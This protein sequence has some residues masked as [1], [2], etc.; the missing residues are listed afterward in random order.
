M[1]LKQAV[2]GMPAATTGVTEIRTGHIIANIIVRYAISNARGYPSQNRPS[3]HPRLQGSP[4]RGRMSALASRPSLPVCLDNAPQAH[5]VRQPILVVR[6]ICIPNDR[7]HRAD[8]AVPAYLFLFTDCVSTSH[9]VHIPHPLSGLWVSLVN[10]VIA[11]NEGA[12]RGL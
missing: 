8:L 2:F 9:L 12:Q 1:R 4:S 3:S 10:P 7:R 6:S 11:R 5:I